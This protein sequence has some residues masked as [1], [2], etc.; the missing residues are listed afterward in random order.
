[1]APT[2]FVFIKHPEVKTLGGP[3]TRKALDEIY[4]H[5]GWKEATPEEVQAFETGIEQRQAVQENLTAEMVDAVRKRD[6]L[7]QIA[8]DRGVD[9]TQHSSMAELATAVKATLL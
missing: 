2:D 5:Q 9:P 1:M 4:A 3:V 8:L 7:D 6:E